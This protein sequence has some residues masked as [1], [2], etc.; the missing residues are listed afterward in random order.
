[1]HD[2]PGGGANPAIPWTSVFD[3]T[4]NVRALGEIQARGFRAAT[5]LVDRF[6]RLTDGATTQR[7]AAQ[8]AKDKGPSETTDAG[9][10]RMLERWEHLVGQ[11]AGVLRRGEAG[12][13]GQPPVVDLVSATATGVVALHGVGLG[14]VSAEVWLHNRDAVD[15]GDVALRCSDLM[16]DD[17]SVISADRVSFDPGRVSMVSRSSRGVTVDVDLHGD[18]PAALYRGTI[19][20]EG[21]R[22]VWLPV[23]LTVVPGE[24]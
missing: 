24:R 16:C 8:T 18:E 12:P 6:V 22:E 19:F 10:D 9:V 21:Y 11:L 17:G 13:D 4:L 14:A 7:P 3:P 5:E 23:E 15:L 20:V 1:M 2:R